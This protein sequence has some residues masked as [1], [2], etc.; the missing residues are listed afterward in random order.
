[1][2]ERTAG[3]R[4]LIESDTGTG[5]V[6][7]ANPGPGAASEL[8]GVDASPDGTVWAVGD[9]TPSTANERT[10]IEVACPG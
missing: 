9:Y 1:M 10:L 4:A 6:V 7:D 5:F 2:A 3:S 8:R